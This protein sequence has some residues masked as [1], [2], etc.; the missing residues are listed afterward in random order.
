MELDRRRIPPDGIRPASAI[1]SRENG[2]P[3]EFDIEVT[4]SELPGAAA[5]SP[6]F[7]ANKAGYSELDVNGDVERCQTNR[8]LRAVK[9]IRL[10]SSTPSARGSDFFALLDPAKA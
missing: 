9:D 2:A 4:S 1:G 8:D 5:S 6:A 3:L 7:T 10:T